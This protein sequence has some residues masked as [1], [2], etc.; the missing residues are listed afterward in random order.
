MPISKQR[1]QTFPKRKSNQRS[2]TSRLS[3]DDLS[4]AVKAIVCFVQWQ[5]YS[6]EIESLQKGTSRNQ[7][8]YSGLTLC[9]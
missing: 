1:K 7:A 8:I 5:T 9:W 6:E 2:S 4:G 3:V